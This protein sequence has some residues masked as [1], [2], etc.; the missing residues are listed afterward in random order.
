MQRRLG[1]TVF[2]L[3]VNLCNKRVD[4]SIPKE[5]NE[6]RYWGQLLAVSAPLDGRSV[7]RDLQ[8]LRKQRG[9]GACSKV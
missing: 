6:N 5:E 2:I 7:L 9:E 4:D 1:N 3:G 8:M